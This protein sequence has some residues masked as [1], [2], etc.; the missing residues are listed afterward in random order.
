MTTQKLP[1]LEICH[2]LHD[3]F[4]VE[5]TKGWPR[6]DVDPEGCMERAA[7]FIGARDALVAEYGVNWD[8]FKAAIAAP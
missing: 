3:L 4:V 1:I 6:F 7:E 8:Q 2:K 5:E